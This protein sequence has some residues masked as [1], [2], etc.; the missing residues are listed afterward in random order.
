[1]LAGVDVYGILAAVV[2]LAIAIIGGGLAMAWRLGGLERTVN[3][4]QNK[5]DDV[6]D[7]V[8]GIEEKLDGRRIGG[9]RW[10]DPPGPRPRR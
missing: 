2:P 1:M 10:T 6:S 4:L 3:D 5:V 7:T 8:D 9:R